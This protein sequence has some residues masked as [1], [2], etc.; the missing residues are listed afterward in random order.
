MRGKGRVNGLAYKEC[1][2]CSQNGAGGWLVDYGG[3]RGLASERLK[4][5]LAPRFFI[6]RH[7]ATM[8]KVN[9]S[10]APII[11]R[12]SSLSCG[13]GLLLCFLPV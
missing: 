8:H 6:I 9:F 7:P 11:H 5:T 3:N 13:P 2:L 1:E 4:V 12:L 10:S